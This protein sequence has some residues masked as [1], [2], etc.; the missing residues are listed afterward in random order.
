MCP[1]GSSF[2]HPKKREGTR[3]KKPRSNYF[4]GKLVFTKKE[5]Y[6]VLC[7]KERTKKKK[8]K[9]ESERGVFEKGTQATKRKGGVEINNDGTV[10]EG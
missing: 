5:K 8:T 4:R 9:M 10:I 3:G 2:P 1:A 6:R 7:R